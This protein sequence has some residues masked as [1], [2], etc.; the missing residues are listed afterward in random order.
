MHSLEAIFVF[1]R[2]CRPTKSR[3]PRDR[4]WTRTAPA[5]APGPF[6]PRSRKARDGPRPRRRTLRG[7]RRR[8]SPSRLG[9]STIAGHTAPCRRARHAPLSAGIFRRGIFAPDRGAV[10]GRRRNRN[11]WRAL[12]WVRENP[13][14]SPRTRGPHNH[15]RAFSREVVAHRPSMRGFGVWVPAFAGTTLRG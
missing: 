13:T 4:P 2:R 5:P 3:P 10:F 14:S 8:E 6:L 9:P 12:C 11:S 7:L 1:A 15:R